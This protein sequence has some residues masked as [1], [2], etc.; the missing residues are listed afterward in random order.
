M[1]GEWVAIRSNESVWFFHAKDFV[2][3]KPGLPIW[4]DLAGAREPQG[5]AIALGPN[6]MIYLVGEGGSK[7]RP[8]TL[9]TMTCALPQ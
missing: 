3:G 2:S 1:D 4:V 9:R 5:E 6:R 7:G 8:G